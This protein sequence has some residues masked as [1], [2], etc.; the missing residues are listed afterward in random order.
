MPARCFVDTN[1]FVYARDSSEPAKQPVAASAVERLWHSRNGRTSMQILNEYYVTVTRKLT[2]GIPPAI[3]WSDV[4]ALFAWS[5]C[6]I[7]RRLVE[8]AHAIEVQ[9][10]LS[11]W[12]SLV[13]AAARAC[14]CTALLTEDM[15]DGQVVGGVRLVN[16]FGTG[17]NDV[18][19]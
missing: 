7:D 2:P 12:D 17:L 10:A 6:P 3:A 4:E 19:S 5:P 1:V 11:W 15:Q 8:D 13:V 16:P 14:D 9:Y 18:L